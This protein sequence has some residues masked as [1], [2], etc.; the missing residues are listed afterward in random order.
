LSVP[1]DEARTLSGFAAGQRAER[2]KHATLPVWQAAESA[3]DE[4]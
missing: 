4:V 1:V 3:H 2:D